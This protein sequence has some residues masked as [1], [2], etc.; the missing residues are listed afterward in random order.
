M[1]LPTFGS[2]P[3]DCRYPGR[4]L[5]RGNGPRDV[6]GGPNEGL[7]GRAAVACTCNSGV[8]CPPWEG[9]KRSERHACTHLSGAVQ[10]SEMP[11]L[12]K[13]RGDKTET[14]VIAGAQSNL[15]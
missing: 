7:E 5:I 12:T 13:S 8:R 2:S 11:A 4:S 10:I 3:L 9:L 14:C 6:P 15:Q 1:H